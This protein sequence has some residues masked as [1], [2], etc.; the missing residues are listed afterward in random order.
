M[1]RLLPWSAVT[2]VLVA[3]VGVA[4]AARPAEEVVKCDTVAPDYV[5]TARALERDGDV[6]T[7][8]VLSIV[9]ESEPGAFVQTPAVGSQ[10][11]V[12]YDP[13]DEDSTNGARF[14]HVGSDYWVP[15]YGGTG[16]GLSSMID[17]ICGGSPVTTYLDGSHID[18]GWLTSPQ[19]QQWAP[20]AIAAVALLTVGVAFLTFRRWRSNPSG[21]REGEGLDDGGARAPSHPADRK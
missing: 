13:G 17:S 20:K 14:L 12:F 9:D 15:V 10:I 3:V 6:V 5:I 4:W 11:E 19:I 8:L 21:P 7:F 2:L 18:T 1:R 16:A